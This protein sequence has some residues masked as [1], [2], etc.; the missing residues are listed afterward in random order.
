MLRVLVAKGCTPTGGLLTQQLREAGILGQPETG[1]ISWGCAYQGGLPCLNGRAGT[2]D[3]YHELAILRDHGILV[4][5]T[6]PV[7]APHYQIPLPVLGRKFTHKGG[8]DLIKIR[9]Q[10]G[11]RNWGRRRDFWSEYIPSV[12][13]FRVWVYRNAHLGTYEKVLVHPEWKARLV[14]RNYHNGYAFQLVPEER[15]PRRAVEA[16]IQSIHAMELDFGA[17]DIL[18][19]RDGRYYVLEVNTAPGVEDGRRQAFQ[20]LVKHIVAWHKGGFKPRK[21]RDEA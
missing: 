14:G 19:G 17:V 4:P 8:R 13:E 1:I 10:A 3:K 7:A 2:V 16:A 11:L 21:V 6:W 12:T 18:Q 15:I 9:T 20:G 5:R